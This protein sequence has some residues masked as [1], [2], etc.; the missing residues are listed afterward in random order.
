VIRLQNKSSTLKPD[1]KV[2]DANRSQ[3][4]EKYDGTA[5]A[6]AELSFT[7]EPGKAFYVQ[8]LPYSS[9]GAYELSATPQNAFDALEPNDDVLTAVASAMGKTIEASI[10]DS[11][12]EDWFKISG[13]TAKSVNI[14]LE[15]MSAT[16]KPDVKI[17]SSTKSN[18]GEKYDGTAG[19]NDRQVQADGQAGE[20]GISLCGFLIE[21]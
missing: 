16:L 2:Y 12:D 10:M 6:S 8:V 21:G 11:K 4:L 17:Y 9:T 3:Q 20:L 1:F 13:A 14:V 15:N 5:G 7:A 18:I 19:A